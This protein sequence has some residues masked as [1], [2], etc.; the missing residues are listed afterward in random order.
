[1]RRAVLGVLLLLF[2]LSRP[3]W[4]NPPA[5]TPSPFHA[6]VDAPPADNRLALLENGYGALILR[7]HLIRAARRSIDLQTFIW[8]NDGSGRLLFWELLEAARRGV[9]VRLLVD[10]PFSE[11]DPR[12][13][14]FAAT[15]HP[16]LEIRHYRPIRS[17]LDPSLLQTVAA[18]VGDFEDVNQRMHNKVFV[19][20]DAILI[21]GGRNVEDAYFDRSTGLN[22]RDR[23]VL[24]V[25]PVAAA[26][27]SSFQAYWTY[28]QSVP[29]RDLRDVRAALDRGD[30]ARF[31][32]EGDYDFGPLAG[33]VRAAAGDSTLIASRFA[34][35]LRPV[36]RAEFVAD[37]PGKGSG[38]FTGEARITRE[39]RD[40][41]SQATEDVVIQTPYLVLSPA[42]RDLI[43]SLRASRPG[44]R[45]RIST[46]SLASTDN[47][48]AYSGNFRLRNTY[49]G[50]LGLEV[51]ELKPLPDSRFRHIPR[52]AEL[53]ALAQPLVAVGRQPRGPFLCLHAKSLVVDRHL[54]FVGSY[55]LDPRSERLNTEAGLLVEDEAFAGALRAAIEDDL[56]PGNSWVIGRREF[57]LKL[58]VM[59][60]LVDGVLSLSPVDLWPLQNTTSFELKPGAAEVPPD[61]PSFRE[62]YRDAGSFPGT[63]GLFSRKEILTHLYKTVGKPLTPVL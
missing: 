52:F 24:A 23:D 36:T 57:P 20:D 2:T 47:V 38:F 4:G 1:M 9:R 58:D 35:A 5:P 18:G 40:A 54:A 29:T 39:L 59:N 48:L 8:S 50:D 6:W 26:A 43:R 27:A 28:E 32:H 13:V 33:E 41:L 53:E 37:I 44:L 62:H 61:H 60:A 51:H 10:Q 42:A 55:N 21:T 11:R 49:V 34:E 19:V 16:N 25:G 45:I 63:E 31:D 46:N 3:L 56:A 17:R 22:Y 12:I 7:V 30:F 15:A 14:A